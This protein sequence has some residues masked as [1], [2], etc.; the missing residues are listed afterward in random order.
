MEY[1]IPHM[2][3]TNKCGAEEDQMLGNFFSA[4]PYKCIVYRGFVQLKVC[5]GQSWRVFNLSMEPFS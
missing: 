3:L 1:E 4:R 5:I 2:T